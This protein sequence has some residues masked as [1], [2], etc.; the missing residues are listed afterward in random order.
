MSNVGRITV[1]HVWLTLFLVNA[2][3][4]IHRTAEAQVGHRPESSPYS[5]LRAKKVLSLVGGFFSGS[6]GKVDVGP[7]SGPYSGARFDLHLG[8][9]AGVTFG[10]GVA[11]LERVLI[12]PTLGPANRTLDTT[13]QAVLLIDAGFDLLF[14]G[15]KT[16]HG[17]IP[18][19]GAGMGMALGTSVDADSL[20]GYSFST[21]FTTGPRLGVWVHPSDRITFRIEARDL[22]WRLKYPD[23]FFSVP[24]QEP[25]ETPVLDANV[26][27]DTEWVHH[28]G[29]TIS[30]GYTIGN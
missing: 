2:L 29:L 23:G 7:A 11:N 10:T 15:E 13:T 24:E 27:K 9:P 12:D 4:G 25:T 6:P 1:Q 26:T 5:D 18:Y 20:S 21:H 19:F 8:G 28:L 3:L 14:T 17:L 22:L 16:W 30:I